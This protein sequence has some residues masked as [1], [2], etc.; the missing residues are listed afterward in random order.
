MTPAALHAIVARSQRRPFECTA[1]T[2]CG[3]STILLSHL[4]QR[5][6]AFAVEGADLTVSGGAYARYFVFSLKRFYT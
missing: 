5:H 2:G 3:G 4:S 1:E 6:T